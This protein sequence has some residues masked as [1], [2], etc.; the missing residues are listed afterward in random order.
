MFKELFTESLKGDK[1]Q[2]MDIANKYDLLKTKKVKMSNGSYVENYYFKYED[3]AEKFAKALDKMK[4][5]NSL[6]GA[7]TYVTVSL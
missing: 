7:N 1:K 2:L 4:V 3:D 5:K 6:I